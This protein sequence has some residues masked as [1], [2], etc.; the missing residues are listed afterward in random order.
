MGKD[1]VDDEMSIQTLREQ[2]LGYR[3]NTIGE[4]KKVLQTIWD[5]LPQYSVNK[6]IL[7]F[8]KR[9]RVCVKARGGHFVQVFK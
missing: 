6:V 1:S 3:M 2:E 4:L 8:V 7:S 5:D 9:L